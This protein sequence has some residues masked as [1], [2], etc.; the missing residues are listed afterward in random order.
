MAK[1]EKIMTVLFADLYD[2]QMTYSREK[3]ILKL[4]WNYIVLLEFIK[5][6]YNYIQEV[7]DLLYRIVKTITWYPDRVMEY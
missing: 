6:E 1:I 3:R 5:C 7:F 2:M 4:Y